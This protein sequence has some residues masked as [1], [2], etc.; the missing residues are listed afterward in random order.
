MRALDSRPTRTD[1]PTLRKSRTALSSLGD[2]AD[3]RECALRSAVH[4]SRCVSR[5]H[6]AGE[7]PIAGYER[8]DGWARIAAD[9]ACPDGIAGRWAASRRRTARRPPGPAGP[10]PQ[11]GENRIG[12]SA[13]SISWHARCGPHAGGPRPSPQ[14][15]PVPL[16]ASA[17][18]PPGPVPPPGTGCG[19]PRRLAPVRRAG[20][21]DYRPACGPQ[22]GFWRSFAS[23]IPHQAP[24][25]TTPSRSLLRGPVPRAGRGGQAVVHRCDCRPGMTSCHQVA[26]PA[27][28]GQSRSR[29]RGC[30][31]ADTPA[32]GHPPRRRDPVPGPTAGDP[33]LAGYPAG[34]GGPGGA[35]RDDPGRPAHVPARP[36]CG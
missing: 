3:R 28:K 32:D 34:A 35:H 21:G 15:S 14:P 27:R 18:C 13:R 20:G 7:S 33:E 19:Q 23:G 22:S 30:L 5:R 1:H 17:A 26:R 29:H 11:P 4:Q 6:R 8:G 31:L 24:A 2:H 12:R 16:A 9:A 10:A 25:R 36:P